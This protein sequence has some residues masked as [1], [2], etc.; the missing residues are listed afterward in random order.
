MGRLTTT[1]ACTP[2]NHISYLMHPFPELL[3]RAINKQNAIGW[4]QIFRGRLSLAWGF[5]YM[6]WQ[7][8]HPPTKKSARLDP[9]TWTTRIIKWAMSTV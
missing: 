2:A 8:L 9:D 7:S 5:C 4:H 1:T 3:D 6:K